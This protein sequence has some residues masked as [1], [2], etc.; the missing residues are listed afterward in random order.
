M[1]LGIDNAYPITPA[2]AKNAEANVVCVYIG[3]VNNG[4]RAWLPQHANDLRLAG[5]RLLPI[6]VGANVGYNTN[7]LSLDGGK[8]DGHDTVRCLEQFGFAKN[9]MPPVAL[10]LEYGTYEQRPNDTEN[11]IIGWSQVITESGYFPVGYMTLYMARNFKPLFP[12]GVWVASWLGSSRPPDI[13]NLAIPQENFNGVGWQYTD[14]YNVGGHYDG[15]IFPSQWWPLHPTDSNRNGVIPVDN[16]GKVTQ[17]GKIRYF[18]ETGHGIGGGFR[19][20]WENWGGL[21]TF[22][23]PLSEE[24]VTPDGVTTQYFERAIFTHKPGSSKDRYDVVLQ[25]VGSMVLT[26]N[27]ANRTFADAF[28][29]KNFN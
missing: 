5:Y 17:D 12:L 4:G 9:F 7:N 13:K 8:A 2:Q 24:F 19:A 25:L 15:N 3:G 1:L 20:F 28:A 14:Q 23:F 18:T 26:Q 27:N 16:S 21:Q 10:D 11:Y 6:Y 22:G 29:R